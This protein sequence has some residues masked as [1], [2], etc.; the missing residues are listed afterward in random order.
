M[1]SKK[2]IFYLENIVNA[3]E[4]THNFN[5]EIFNYEIK[6]NLEELENKQ[7][8]YTNLS[9]KDKVSM[10]LEIIKSY[11]NGNLYKELINNQDINRIYLDVIKNYK[12]EDKRFEM[13]ILSLTFGFG[14]RLVSQFEKLEGYFERVTKDN[15]LDVTSS[16]SVGNIPK[17]KKIKK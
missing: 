11:K 6:P 9:N 7:F 5:E 16:E 13:A 12:K 15:N 3:Y 1:N 4:V 2:E 8:G 17:I 14:S 10:E